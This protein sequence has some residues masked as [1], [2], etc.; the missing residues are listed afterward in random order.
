MLDYSVGNICS[1]PSGAVLSTGQSS[2]QSNKSP[3]ER[4]T[5]HRGIQDAFVHDTVIIR[6]CALPQG[7]LHG[8]AVFYPSGFDGEILIFR[9]GFHC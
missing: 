4:G 8:A 2:E 3:F 7:S 6:V 1:L 5:F 9:K